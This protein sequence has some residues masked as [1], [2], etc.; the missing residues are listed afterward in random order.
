MP[1]NRAA[2]QNSDGKAS[3]IPAKNVS[4]SLEQ[5]SIRMKVINLGEN[6]TVL[7][8]FIAEM[9]DRTVQKDSLRFRTNLERVGEIFAYEISKTLAYAPKEVTTPLG[10][11]E[12]ELPET[13][14]VIAT[15]LRAGLP[16]QTGFLRFFDH[17]E[18]AFVAAFRKYG[19]GGYSELRT[20]Y[21]TCPD[22]TGKTLILTDAMLATGA[23]SEM[24]MQVLQEHGG[25]PACIHLA[26]PIASRDAVEHFQKTL[27]DSITLWTAAIDE[28]LTSKNCIIPG[29]G[30]AGNLAFGG[31][32]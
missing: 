24:A 11:A 31:K 21:C 27:P 23:S 19:K 5:Q 12:M 13:K 30:D 6:N 2:E 16:L 22:L 20:D 1:E 14:L 28:E 26:I 8:N 9:R 4:L 3:V 17:A 29:L 15:I 10:I 32:K 7:S 18:T 25:T